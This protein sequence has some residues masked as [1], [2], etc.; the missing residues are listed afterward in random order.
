VNL[1]RIGIVGLIAL[2]VAFIWLNN[3]EERQAASKL[4]GQTITLERLRKQREN[5]TYLTFPK[6]LFKNLSILGSPIAT[7]KQCIAY[8][9]KTNPFPLL[10]TSVEKLVAIYYREGLREGVRPDLA[11]AQALLETG[12]FSYG[13]DVY[14]HQN[15]YA[16]I[17]ATG[18]KVK[19]AYFPTPEIGVRSQIQHLLGYASKRRP[20][21]IIVD[22]R[23]ELLAKIPAKYGKIQTWVGLGGNWAVPG[24]NYGA[25]IL[26][27]HRRILNM[28]SRD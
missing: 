28:P 24:V 14:P 2:F 15:N 27:I 9:Y 26:E 25:N 1:F 19:G 16:G 7:Q 23:Y 20:S 13:G 4:Q 3:A 21:E 11:F 8:L 6:I 5:T 17:G 10:S 22:P 12:H 18:N